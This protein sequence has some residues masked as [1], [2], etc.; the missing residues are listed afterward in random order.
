MEENVGVRGFDNFGVCGAIGGSDNSDSEEIGRFGVSVFNLGGRFF[1]S[2][3]DSIGRR[4]ANDEARDKGTGGR[5]FSRSQDLMGPGASV[6][7]GVIGPGKLWVDELDGVLT[8]SLRWE[9][10]WMSTREGRGSEKRARVDAGSGWSC[11][12]MLRDRVEATV[13]LRLCHDVGGREGRFRFCVDFDEYALAS[14]ENERERG[15]GWEREERGALLRDATEDW[16]ERAMCDSRLV[17]GDGASSSSLF[18]NNKKK[19]GQR[20]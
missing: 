5:F 18:R 10:I 20:M 7:S 3:K 12:G 11:S 1:M 6:T 17:R 9:S 4:L 14:P 16:R 8:C 13:R 15:C 19:G 2:E